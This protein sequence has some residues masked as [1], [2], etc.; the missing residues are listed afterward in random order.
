MQKALHRAGP[1]EIS[2]SERSLGVGG[3]ATAA[4]GHGHQRDAGGCG[5][6]STTQTKGADQRHE[7]FGILTGDSD[8]LVGLIGIFSL[9]NHTVTAMRDHGGQLHQ[10]GFGE[11][12]SSLSCQRDHGN[13][14]NGH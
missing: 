2:I 1:F 9:G 12:G 7:T 10:L 14:G 6:T 3:G 8:T 4:T 13:Q 5:S 11:G